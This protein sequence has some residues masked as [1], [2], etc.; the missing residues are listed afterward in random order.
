MKTMTESDLVRLSGGG[1]PA[2]QPLTMPRGWM[3]TPP[4]AFFPNTLS[5]YLRA[6]GLSI[7][8]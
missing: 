7:A 6:L 1:D 2:S 5:E 4:P 3:P 8:A